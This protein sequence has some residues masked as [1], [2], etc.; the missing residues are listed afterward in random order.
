MKIRMALV[1]GFMAV[2]IGGCKTARIKAVDPVP[3][4]SASAEG[5]RGVIQK[6]LMRRGWSVGKEEPGKI[7][8]MLSS[9]AYTAVILL[10]YDAETVNISYSDSTNL[11][12]RKNR[13]GREYIHKNYNKWIKRLAGD[14]RVLGRN[15]KES[16]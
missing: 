3:V 1:I 10:T 15:V 2:T 14:I 11:K 6:A 13:K 7:Y 12:Y 9:S 4:A 5:T 16:T 8:A